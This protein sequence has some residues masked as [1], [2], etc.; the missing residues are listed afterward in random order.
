MGRCPS[1][2]NT[3]GFVW[4]KALVYS[5]STTI[6][7]GNSHFNLFIFIYIV[8]HHVLSFNRFNLLLLQHLRIHHLLDLMHIE[9]NM[10]KSLVRHLFGE[11]DNVRA[12]RACEEFDVHPR[13][14]IRERENG[15]EIM[16]PAPWVLTT[17]ERKMLRRRI[18]EV[19]FPTSMYLI[20]IQIMIFS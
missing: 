12:R 5:P 7:E 20:P 15:T 10:V 16:P 8:C 3:V 18:T 4:V 17:K 2:I 19:R 11:K 13:Q 1:E 9:T 14:W 6:L